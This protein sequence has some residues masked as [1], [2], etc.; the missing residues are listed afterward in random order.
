MSNRINY[1]KYYIKLYIMSTLQQLKEQ[2]HSKPIVHSRNPIFI[3][4]EANNPKEA[5]KETAEVAVKIQDKRSEG[6]N[7]DKFLNRIKQTKLT[8][9]IPKEDLNEP[10]IIESKAPEIIEPVKPPAKVKKLKSKLGAE[11]VIVG[12]TENPPG[13]IAI[14]EPNVVPSEAPKEIEPE[15]IEP[16]AQAEAQAV[17]PKKTRSKKKPLFEI[18]KPAK[19]QIGDTP[20]NARIPKNRPNINIKVSSYIM[21][22]REIFVNFINGL[23]EPY[24]QAITNKTE[25]ISCEN[26]GKSSGESDLLTHQQIVRDYINLYTPYRGLLL[27]HGLG[28]GKTFSSIAIAEGFKSTS[29]I[30]VM[31]PASLRRNYLEEIKKYGDL[32]YRK[33]QYWE[34]ISIETNPE[35]Q[36]S[37]SVALGLEPEFIKRKR[38][39]WL[40]N[41]TKP[42][43]FHTLSSSDRKKIDEQIDEMIQN[44][45][46]FINYNGLRKEKFNN[47]TQNGTIN[48]FDNAVVVIDEAHNLISRIVNKI[49]RSSTFA[50]GERGPKHPLAD[51]L[52][53][54]IY[55]LLLRASNCRVVLLTGTPIIN[56]PNEIGI[57]FN[58]LRGYIKSWNFT[59]IPKTEN[60]L[61]VNKFSEIFLKNKIMDYISYNPSL[62]ILTVT[63]NPYGFENKITGSGYKGVTNEKK[64]RKNEKGETE[65]VD[66][67]VETDEQFISRIQHTLRENDIDIVPQGTTVDVNTAL[68][69]TLN[70]FIGL[71]IN[72]ETGEVYNTEKFKKRIIGLTSFFRSAQEELL[73]GYEKATDLHVLKIPMSDY[74]FKVYEEAR[75]E[76][77]QSEKTGK[78]D[79]TK[80]KVDKD[81]LFIE[82]TSTYRIFSRLFCN[83]VMPKPPGRPKPPIKMI[84][85]NKNND[86]KEIGEAPLKE[87]EKEK[88]KEKKKTRKVKE[89]TDSPTKPKPKAKTRKQKQPEPELEPEIVIQ[90]VVELETEQIGGAESDDE[91]EPTK[92]MRSEESPEDELIAIPEYR[93]EE[94]NTRTRDELEGDE[95]L[96]IEGGQQYRQQIKDTMNFLKSNSAEYLSPQGLTIYSPK[97]LAMLNNIQDPNH[98]G[99]HLIYSQFR[100]MEGIGI[101]CLVLE[102]NGFTQFKIKKTGVDGW[103]LDIKEEDL[104]KPTFALYT[105]TEEADER[106]IIRNIYNGDWEY[107]PTGLATELKKI[108]NNNMMGEIIKMLMITAAGSEGINLRNTRYVHL[109]EPY[110][111]PVRLEQVIGRARR[112]CSHKA[113]PRAL[114]TVEVFLY[115]MTFTAKQLAS[116]EAVELK[117]HDVGKKNRDIPLTSDEALYEISSIK[118]EI[119]GQLLK[120]I[121]EASIDCAI[122]TQI[123]SKRSR[124]G[125]T[126]E[127][128]AKEQLHCLSFGSPTV[129]MFTYNPSYTQ[130]ENDTVNYL[131][132]EVI[133]WAG[134][135]VTI[136]I[137]EN[138]KQVSKKYIIREN[139][140]EVYDFE[141]YQQ[142]LEVP[143]FKPVLVGQMQKQKNGKY[144]FIPL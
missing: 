142:A 23:F 83:F 8:K 64:E 72:T 36:H 139:T 44:K 6:Y 100:S 87:T 9:V 140:D 124:E 28:S 136:K 137:T 92:L 63:R 81:G 113:L 130:D 126:K 20:M 58:I 131:N 117:K 84:F 3:N 129:Q 122:H 33:N 88:E 96:E 57:L 29:R 132:K 70:E 69:D 22:N 98:L 125:K 108:S 5:K 15:A 68:P 116:D 53:L 91:H 16:E 114:Q 94:T 39:A 48:I 45:Y 12:E 71:F 2:L 119:T 115:L 32:L 99:L 103:S 25:N 143:G 90:P 47:M 26:I 121:K 78:K 55:E 19:I 109:M 4:L 31:T 133:E 43:N 51:P 54:K 21:N 111:H 110:W 102:Q 52:S 13:D 61:D 128:L 67:G 105:G 27:Y 34:W 76:E 112:I 60:K 80:K 7:P 38:G 74:Q 107:I 37:L 118:E 10:V 59:I 89:K 40:V 141:T 95:F 93:N 66:R 82:P 75:I 101:F 62:K 50:K 17:V 35:T 24:R 134:T 65:F 18:T 73:P 46:T 144:T 97:F 138:G 123:S 86:T 11:F 56:Y 127:Q 120:A 77:R 135:P 42:S 14:V 49:N 79:A 30:I 104:G 85:A 41:V 1:K 106:E